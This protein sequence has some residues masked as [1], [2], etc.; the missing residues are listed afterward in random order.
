MKSNG[1]HTADVT[2]LRVDQITKTFG[3][4]KAVQSVTIGFHTG[5]LMALLGPNGAGKT[6]L[7]RML[8]GIL[9]PDS[10]AVFLNENQHPGRDRISR[11]IGY[12]PQRIIVWKD[13][14]CLEQLILMGKMYN[15][16][17]GSA[18]SRASEL[19]ELFNLTSKTNV[20]AKTLSGGMQRRLSVALAMV[21]RPAVLVLD[22]PEAGLDPQSRVL[23]RNVL[24][25]LCTEEG[26][27][28]VLSTHDMAEAELLSSRVAVMHRGQLLADGS[29]A[30]LIQRAGSTYLVEL[31]LEGSAK[32]DRERLISALGRLG[33]RID[34]NE[35]TIFL[36]SDAQGA[37]V[38]PI[39]TI[40]ASE[41]I[42]ISELRHRKRTLEDVFLSLTSTQ[43]ERGAA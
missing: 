24:H 14:T 17:R 39:R 4:L 25:H 37:L 19:I 7:I 41:R 32:V 27:A 22:E 35:R 43:M 18:V 26:T 2:P 34:S 10:G 30:Q 29:P 33:A 6:T 12:C 15:L 40:A 13:L 36:H 8:T 38:R 3:E 16:S 23:I 28:V 5:E 42:V 20:L 11:S 21:H 31:R 1:T 9:K